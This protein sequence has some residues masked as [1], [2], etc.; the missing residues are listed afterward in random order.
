MAFTFCAVRLAF[1]ISLVIHSFLSW[2]VGL[3]ALLQAMDCAWAC[4]AW[5]CAYTC[6]MANSIL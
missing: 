4:V 3:V 2:C 1:E 6:A 5:K